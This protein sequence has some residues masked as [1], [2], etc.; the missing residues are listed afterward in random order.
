M[1]GDHVCGAPSQRRFFAKGPTYPRL[2]TTWSATPPLDSYAGF[3]TRA[4]E[5]AS[6]A[7]KLSLPRVDISVAS[8]PNP[9]LLSYSNHS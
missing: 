4:S 9:E 6:K 3:E 7:A 8:R 1:M 2:L 5:P